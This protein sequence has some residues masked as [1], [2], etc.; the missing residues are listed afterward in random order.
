MSSPASA[1][2]LADS[3]LARLTKD[4]RSVRLVGVGNLAIA[5]VID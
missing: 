2:V 3:W 5:S 1:A 4:R